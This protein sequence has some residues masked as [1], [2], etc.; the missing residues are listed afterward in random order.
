[1]ERICV[2][3]IIPVSYTHLVRDYYSQ[4]VDAVQNGEEAIDSVLGGSLGIG[5]NYKGIS[6]IAY[7]SIVDKDVYKR[8]RNTSL[9]IDVT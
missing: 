5:N 4:L 8:Q 3:L 1:M 7:S 9:S 6:E 2:R